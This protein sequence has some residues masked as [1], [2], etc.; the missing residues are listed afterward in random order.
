MK[1]HR[2]VR[3]NDVNKVIIII[4]SVLIVTIRSKISHNT[5]V[6]ENSWS[7]TLR[8]F[9]DSGAAIFEQDPTGVR[10]AANSS[11]SQRKQL[12]ALFFFGLYS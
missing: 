5:T 7:N 11:R 10:F 3:L 1:D 9:S 2:Q 12:S 4:D 8:N 6:P